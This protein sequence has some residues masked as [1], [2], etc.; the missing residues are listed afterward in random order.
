[1]KNNLT[2]IIAF[3]TQTMR[4][5][6]PDVQAVLNAVIGRIQGIALAHDMLSATNKTS[7]VDFDDYLR[8]LCANITQPP[9][10]SIEVGA[11]DVS[12]PIDR[13]VPAGLIV[14]ELVTNS[15]KYAFGNSGGHITVQMTAGSGSEVCVSVED[16][17]RGME[18]P[19]KPGL[20]LKLVEGLAQQ[21]QGRVQYEKVETGSRTVLCFP[22]AL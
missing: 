11:Q 8:A 18:L 17:G 15:I 13:A 21:I 19:P 14:N 16:D 10:V 9:N 1:V 12:V 5:L 20:G 3:L 6:S 2:V 7:S 4:G 22:V